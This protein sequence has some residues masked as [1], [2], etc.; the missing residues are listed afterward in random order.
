MSKTVQICLS[1][2][3][4]FETN[5]FTVLW[6]NNDIRISKS[7]DLDEEMLILSMLAHH[8]FRNKIYTFGEEELVAIKQQLKEK[9]S[10][11]LNIL[12]F[13]GNFMIILVLSID[14]T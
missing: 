7:I 8:L 12:E 10:I 14:F 9:H 11:N 1:N 4:N 2:Y 13:K 6:F 5:F 3:S